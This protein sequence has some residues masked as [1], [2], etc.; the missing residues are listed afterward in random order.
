MCILSGDGLFPPRLGRWARR[1]A[2]CAEVWAILGHRS[3][4]ALEPTPGAEGQLTFGS[5]S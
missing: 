2:D 3:R 1:G 4:A 5:Q